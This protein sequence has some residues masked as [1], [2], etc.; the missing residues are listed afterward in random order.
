MGKGSVE[1]PKARLSQSYYFIFGRRW[2]PAEEDILGIL[3]STLIIFL[4]KSL[5]SPAPFMCYITPRA[6]DFCSYSALAL[7]RVNHEIKANAGVI[8][9]I[10]H[11]KG[12]GSS[13]TIYEKGLQGRPAMAENDFSGAVLRPDF[14]S[15][16]PSPQTLGPKSLGSHSQPL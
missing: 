4:L 14:R 9:V 2:Q 11:I 3:T 5:S 15:L 10:R 1:S 13:H 16:S 12:A 8:G 7:Y 6:P